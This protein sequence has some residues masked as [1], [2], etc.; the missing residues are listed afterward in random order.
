[1]TVLMTAAVLAAGGTA[2]PAHAA[3][4]A[5]CYNEWHAALITAALGKKCSYIDA[6]TADKVAKAEAMRLQCFEAKATPAE[7]AD[8]DKRMAGARAELAQRVAAMQ[9]GAEMK[10]AYDRNVANFTK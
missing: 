6:A 9:C 1:M 7:K 10:A 3:V 8:L 5:K 4:D 2:R